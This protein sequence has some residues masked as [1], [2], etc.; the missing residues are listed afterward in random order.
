[1]A[2]VK[3]REEHRSYVI[4]PNF[5]DKMSIGGGFLKLRNLVEAVIITASVLLPILFFVPMSKTVKIYVL[6]LVGIPLLAIGC[7]GLNGDSLFQFLKYWTAFR[8]NKRISRYNPHMKKPDDV[9]KA[10]AK[11]EDEMLPRDRILKKISELTGRTF[12]VQDQDYDALYEDVDM[13]VKFDDEDTVLSFGY[14]NDSDSL[15]SKERKRREKKERQLA[16]LGAS[17]MEELHFDRETH[18][19]IDARPHEASVD[20]ITEI[21]TFIEETK[22]SNKPISFEDQLNSMAMSH[23]IKGD[24]GVAEAVKK[25]DPDKDTPVFDLIGM[26][27][28]ED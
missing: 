6:I 19:I 1:M 20:E 5:I 3:K 7:V 25:M 14:K 21:T 9:R 24:E 23:I 17:S 11:K 15:T 18:R 10:L 27:V 2:N 22:A 16:A 8:K 28:E 13:M 26:D 4:P 12:E